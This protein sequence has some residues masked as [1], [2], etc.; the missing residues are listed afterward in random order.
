VAR[1]AWEWIR[2]CLPFVPLA[3]SFALALSLRTYFV[4]DLAAPTGALSGGG[5]AFYFERLASH[6]AITGRSIAADCALNY[7]LCGANPNPPLFPTLAALSA[8]LGTG[9]DSGVA[10]SLMLWTALGGALAVIP[11]F[12]V[13]REVAGL[14]GAWIAAFL[15]ALLPPHVEGSVATRASPAP[16]ALF[17]GLVGLYFLLLALRN[18]MPLPEKRLPGKV[19]PGLRVSLGRNRVALLYSSMAGWSF[20]ALALTGPGWSFFAVLLAVFGSV[21]LAWTHF[22]G[23]AVGASGAC[24]SLAGGL[25]LLASAPVYLSLE[26]PQPFLV[27]AAAFTALVATGAVLSFS[28]LRPRHGPWVVLGLLVLFGLLVSLTTGSGAEVDATLTGA[29]DRDRVLLGLSWGVVACAAL[30]GWPL[31]R[32]H[33]MGVARPVHCLLFTWLPL[34]F[35]VAFTEPEG[36]FLAVPGLAVASGFTASRLLDALRPVVK[37]E[38]PPEPP[39]WRRMPQPTAAT[40]IVLLVIAPN[41]FGAFDAAVPFERD[42]AYDVELCLTLPEGLR[43]TEC[44][45]YRAYLGRWGPDL[46]MPDEPLPAFWDWFEQRDAEAPLEERPAFVSWWDYGTAAVARG[47][48]PA[49]ADSVAD[50]HLAGNFLLAQGEAEGLAYLNARLIEGDWSANRGL[51]P[52]ITALLSRHSIDSAYVGAVLTEPGSYVGT[53]LG[54]PARYGPREAEL[55]GRNALYVLLKTELLERLPTVG[56]Q[57]DL[58]R[59]LRTHTG[60]SIRYFGVTFQLFPVSGGRTGTFY[61]PVLLSDHRVIR[62]PNGRFIPRDFYTLAA[63]VDGREVPLENLTGEEAVDD[64]RI[65]YRPMFYR[66]MFYRAYVGFTPRD[67]GALQDVGVPGLSGPR[68]ADAPLPGWNLSHW[69]AVY[70][71]AYYNP[72]PPPEMSEHRDETVPLNLFDALTIEDRIRAGEENGT[73]FLNPV[74]A[75]TTGVV[76][77]QYY[78]GAFVNGTVTLGGAPL[79]GATVTVLDALGIPHHVGTTGPDGRYALLA[80]SGEVNIT[81]SMGRLDGRTLVGAA[82]MSSATLDVSDQAAMREEHDGD[83]DGEPDY[84]ITLDFSL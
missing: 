6:T 66:S 57:A 35:L 15:V 29:P 13:G 17:F 20:A 46:A 60:N 58:Y 22:R 41:C 71:T 39:R 61:A 49:V 10:V 26:N 11:A 5:E 51:T 64:V 24:F 23:G 47:G 21:S 67:A 82:W 40:A 50:Y 12:L 25:P 68:Q 1:S 28:S 83:G 75:I 69:Q 42:R 44:G 59:E 16:L 9:S 56:A 62:L 3:I 70:V 74:N 45:G 54:D 72:H 4:W 18:P 7:P 19:L 84:R 80:P 37:P 63:V 52:G 34:S 32:D 8:L 31:Y 77:L 38:A 43:S 48:H 27:A 53:V 76:L 14:R 81:V 33:T 65:T 36:A 55:Q 2:R 30:A 79:A 78:D 73:V